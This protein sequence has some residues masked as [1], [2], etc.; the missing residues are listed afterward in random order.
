MFHLPGGELLERESR[1]ADRGRIIR[2]GVQALAVAHTDRDG[3]AAFFGIGMVARDVVAAIVCRSDTDRRAATI[4]PGDAGRERV[5]SAV[6]RAGS[7]HTVEDAT[8]SC[9]LIR[10]TDCEYWLDG[11]V[12]CLTD[13]TIGI[14]TVA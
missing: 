8:F 11:H 12:E 14:V 4:A 3:V 2:R 1:V 7:N 6:S 10:A 13:G 9:A 5:G